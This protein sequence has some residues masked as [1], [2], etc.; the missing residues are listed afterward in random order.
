MIRAS[1][2]SGFCM[3][4]HHINKP[5]HRYLA[6]QQ[7]IM[8]QAV[9]TLN[10]SGFKGLRLRDVAA[11][12]GMLPTGVHYYFPNKDRL[13]AACYQQA[14]ERHQGFIDQA[15]GA[16]SMPERL[17]LF[18]KAYAWD[19]QA[20]MH[21]ER[22]PMAVFNDVAVLDD[23]EVNRSYAR[24]FLRLARLLAHRADESWVVLSAR[25]HLVL[26]ALLWPRNLVD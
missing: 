12:I 2:H 10:H 5:T 6:R 25:A 19:R 13:A 14:I 26:A 23:A 11:A 21:G 9:L 7:A 17:H 18:I 22:P 24:M 20:I 8:D 3:A 16:V 4:Q 15:H 1:A